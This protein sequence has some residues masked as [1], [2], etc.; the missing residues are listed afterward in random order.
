MEQQIQK[1]KE[2]REEYYT[3][4]RVVDKLHKQLDEEVV[5]LQKNCN[6]PEFYKEDDGDYHSPGYYYTC[7]VCGYF[8]RFK[9][10]NAKI[11]YR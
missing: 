7:K 10:N 11:E 4:C 9:P 6:H 1:V 5:I 8:T 2:L 3:M